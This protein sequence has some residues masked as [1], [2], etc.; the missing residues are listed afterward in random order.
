MYRD[1]LL[2]GCFEG[3][4]THRDRCYMNPFR[5]IFMSSRED[6]TLKMPDLGYTRLSVKC[7]SQLPIF[8]LIYLAVEK[9][10]SSSDVGCVKQDSQR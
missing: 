1:Q 7:H 8:P 10:S 4:C 9:D 2:T 3:S 6:T 5:K